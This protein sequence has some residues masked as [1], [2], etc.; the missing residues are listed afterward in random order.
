MLPTGVHIS[1]GNSKLGVD[2]PSVNLPVG[3][4]CREDAPCYKRC[5]ARRGRFSFPHN[6]SLL[7]T[8]LQIW[9][10]SPVNFERSILV[11]AFASKFFRWHATGDIPSKEYL[12]MMVRVANALPDTR[13][14]CFT[15]KY[16]LINSF[17]DN[18]GALP[19]NLIIVF[20]AWGDWVP[21]NPHH[22]PMAYIHFKHAGELE[23]PNAHKCPNYCG[24]CVMS[25]CSCWDM[26]RGVH[27]GFVDC[28]IFNE[29]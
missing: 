11:A 16:E 4:S 29:H 20:S 22:L 25:G 14:L 5:Y 21:D 8:N 10:D 27:D 23:I 13:F 12:E 7:D 1:H 6:K 24:D 15:K 9:N 26:N 18:G 28:V 19:K 2:I 3:A 17:I